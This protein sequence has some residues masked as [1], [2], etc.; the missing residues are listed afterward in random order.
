MESEDGEERDSPEIQEDE[1]VEDDNDEMSP[2]AVP[3]EEEES[4]RIVGWRAGQ[5][6]SKSQVQTILRKEPTARAEY[7]GV[8]KAINK[9]TAKDEEDGLKG[10]PATWQAFWSTVPHLD[11]KAAYNEHQ[12]EQERKARAKR[13]AAV[14]EEAK[15]EWEGKPG[16]SMAEEVVRLE[17]HI[18]QLQQGLKDK[19]RVS[20]EWEMKLARAKVAE[21]ESLI[22]SRRVKRKLDSATYL[23]GVSMGKFNS[24]EG[25]FQ[26]LYQDTIM[27]G[28]KEVGILQRSRNLIDKQI[29]LLKS[30]VRMLLK[31]AAADERAESS[32]GDTKSAGSD[33]KSQRSGRTLR[34]L[35]ALPPPSPSLSAPPSS[36]GAYL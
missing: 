22:H 31:V 14:A 34:S 1:D 23:Y 2:W 8:M 13:K 35:K 30:H 24:S 16:E 36:P 9:A 10:M 7:R 15:P 19:K 25:Y 11:A 26:F 12:R 3:R 32:M 20:E 17:E 18:R 5:S 28:K 29:D 21:E 27:E 4:D 33:S 6:L